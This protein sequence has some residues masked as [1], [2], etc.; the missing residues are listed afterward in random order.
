MS[1]K[2]RFQP[3]RLLALA[4]YLEK[5]PRKRFDYRTWVGDDWQGDQKLSC[6][7]TACALGHGPSVP[8]LYR[9][10]LRLRYAYRNSSNDLFPNAIHDVYLAVVGHRIRDT[11]SFG[12]SIKAAC[13]VFGID[14]DDA[15]FLFNPGYESERW[16]RFAPAVYATAKQVA[17][18]IRRYVK[19]MQKEFGK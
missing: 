1:K 8:S 4:A 6:G 2:V 16:D 12:T 9:A 11:S 7:T 5:L 14:E 17:K 15:Q 19:D 18:H 3:Q 10:G 13:I